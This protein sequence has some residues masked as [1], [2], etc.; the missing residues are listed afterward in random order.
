LQRADEA[1]KIARSI[2]AEPSELHVGYSPTP[3][4]EIL[5]K[6]LRAF[7]HAMPKILFDC[8][9]GPTKPFSTAYATAGFNSD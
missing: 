7:Q 1:V 2:A 8:R 4:A 6:T 3:V 9:I 5:P